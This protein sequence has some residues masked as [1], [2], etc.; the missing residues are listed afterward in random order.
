MWK[1]ALIS[2]LT[3]YRK[4]WR[5]FVRAKSQLLYTSVPVGADIATTLEER[6]PYRI[7]QLSY[8]TSQKGNE[9]KVVAVALETLGEAEGF[10]GP[11]GLNPVGFTAKPD[12]GDFIGEPM[13][14][15]M[16]DGNGG[17]DVDKHPVHVVEKPASSVANKAA[18]VP[19]AP[20]PSAEQTGD[21]IDVVENIFA[22][23]PSEEPESDTA[24]QTAKQV[25]TNFDEVVA[26]IT[27]APASDDNKLPSASPAAFS[28]RRPDTE[29]NDENSSGE[30]VRKISARIAVANS[31]P[32]LGGATDG[33]SLKA[34]GKATPPSNEKASKAP[35][36]PAKLTSVVAP[37]G[38]AAPIIPPTALAVPK[39]VPP[40]AV[41][42]ELAKERDPLA[43]LAA[44][45]RRGKPRFLG[46]IMTGILLVCLAL[47]AL[48]SS[49]VLPD[50][51]ISSWFGANNAPEV[52][53]AVIQVEPEPIE[54][55]TTNLPIEE[56][57]D[58]AR[59]PIEELPPVFE[60][61]QEV[62]A[63]E[64]VLSEQILPA[65]TPT[66]PLEMTELEAQ[67]A[68]AVSGIW[69][70]ADTLSLEA[71]ATETLDGLQIASLDPNPTL[72][73]QPA[74]LAQGPS[75]SEVA[76][77]SFTRPPPP[78]VIFDIDERGLVR[79]TPE[80]T[81][82]P[83]GVTVFLGQP[84]VVPLPRPQE[85]AEATKEPDALAQSNV[86]APPTLTPAQ[87]RLSAIRPAPRP[88]D[89]KDQRERATLGGFVRSELARI[90]PQQRPVTAEAQAQA[91]ARALLE[92]ER[93]EI[94][95]IEVALASATP[96][97]VAVSRRAQ[98]RPRELAAVARVRR[99]PAVQTASASA[100]SA[101]AQATGPA[102]AR[103]SRANPTGP[104][105][106]RV[107]AAA[108]QSDAIA[109]GNV[110]LVGVFGTSSNRRALIR[111]PNGRFKKVAIGDRVD[112]GRVAAIDGNSLRYTKGGRTVT[113]Q[114]PSS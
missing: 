85:D 103:S 55:P 60:G 54:E 84:T 61:L 73:D 45:E 71:E 57:V 113:L 59:L 101:A 26:P 92:V 42:A 12:T 107:A 29:E 41:A 86:S 106:G 11:H 30:H 21:D 9:I 97:A 14:G 27:P 77:I 102:V 74:P 111:T 68:Y 16:L 34:H 88:T 100:A 110:A 7:D 20:K 2:P 98:K 72:E 23:T 82:N 24:D 109:L 4:G 83:D 19:E 66:V 36:A 3:T 63:P 51:A 18:V 76:L 50:D 53:L 65:P 114:M 52:E 5:R 40:A 8:D 58:V 69:Q 35:T 6:T 89:L 70:R 96:Q 25:L 81:V 28:S 105:S 38:K 46:L 104:V 37:K 48:L 79:A 15:G 87:L 99:N 108:T 80:G 17:F 95:S 90:R 49:Y 47:A 75:G 39:S 10:I 13:L 56:E 1:G 44:N 32:K 91:I 33:P 43:G 22:E 62:I 31:A 64:P 78:G 93:N 112:G 94:E 67:T